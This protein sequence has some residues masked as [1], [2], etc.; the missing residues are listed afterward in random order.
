MLLVLVVAAQYAED[1]SDMMS[2]ECA[3]EREEMSMPTDQSGRGDVEE[4]EV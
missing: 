1:D 4:E 3:V 2:I